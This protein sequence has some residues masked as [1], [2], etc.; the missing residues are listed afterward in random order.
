MGIIVQDVEFRSS[1]SPKIIKDVEILEGDGGPGTIKLIH[2][3]EGSQFKNINYRV[4]KLNE[5][6]YEYSYSI[7]EGDALMD[8]LK[9]ITC[10][11]K[12]E[13]STIIGGSICKMSNKYHI[14]GDALMH[15][16]GFLGWHT[17]ICILIKSFKLN[18]LFRVRSSVH[19]HPKGN[20]KMFS[21]N[22]I[23]FHFSLGYSK[24]YF[25]PPN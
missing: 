18:A 11:I 5:E 23:K 1:I 25:S 9:V 15:V 22:V 24:V 14:E 6:S 10:D 17:Y 16:R 3:A 12:I 21:H 2:F 20:V 7:I 8:F 19:M 13:P 4:D